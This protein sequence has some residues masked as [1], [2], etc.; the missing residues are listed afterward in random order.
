MSL[1][2]LQQ[3]LGSLAKVIEDNEKLAIPVLAVKL[4]KYLESYPEDRTIG[5]MSRVINKMADNNKSFIKRAELKGLYEKLHTRNTKFAQL[6]ESEL[7]IVENLPTAT[8]TSRDDGTEKIDI[9]EAGDQVLA[10]ALSSVF[11]N[12]PLKM[13]SQ[14]LADKALKSVAS[15]LDV[16][17]LKP[18]SLAVNAGNE[19]FLVIKADY[20]TPKGITSLYVPLQTENNKLSQASVFMGNS[21][22]K[23]LNYVN[24]KKYLTTFAGSKSRITGENILE[25]LTKSA[26]ENREVSD[27]EVA[28]IKLNSSRSNIKSEFSQNQ[29][30]GQKMAEASVKDVE[31]PKS[32]EFVS[33]EK[34]FTS[35]FGIA[36][37]SFGEKIVKT[38][39]EVIARELS[40]YGHKNPQVTV[41][42]S[43]KNTIFY[44]VS[45]D[46]GKVA[47]TVPVKLSEG[48][49]LSPSVIIC[50]GSMLPF[51]DVSIS[52]LYIDNETDYKA[53]ASASPMFGLNPNELINNI[54]S[55]VAQG[56]HAKAEDALNVLADMG[57][58]KA[59][60][61]GFTA[62]LQG[63]G[64]KVAKA[65]STCSK[66]IKNAKVSEHPICSHTGLPLHKVYVDK[67]GNCR[68][69]YR[70][71]MDE[72]YQPAVFNNSKI[73]G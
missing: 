34:T 28:L 48:K 67:D 39:R 2:K 40:G 13:Y 37:F 18:N 52:K 72:T 49:L 5:S 6:F 54:K 19:K 11:D 55:A 14:P 26:S 57:N 64:N 73:F 42:N 66:V 59:Y 71:G 70:K 46:A 31:L 61:I 41:S 65:E 68:P 10:N 62:F 27:A 25:V 36:A 56:N 30:V 15:T 8:V 12:T 33:F 20:D 24:I 7:G 35:P 45:L 44:H 23:E 51:S 29:I 9:Y 21:G 4:A 3:Q 17:N 32:D 53:A 43:D 60:A 22:L 50:N 16:W 1:D 69:I 47:F 63:L 58:E 38:A